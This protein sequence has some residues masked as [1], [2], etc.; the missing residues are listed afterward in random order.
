MTEPGSGL[1]RG[2]AVALAAAAMA[3]GAGG[4]ALGAAADPKPV[5]A[6]AT[7][8]AEPARSGSVLAR[9]RLESS[10]A[11]AE[12]RRAG[13]RIAATPD[14]RSF[15]V[16]SP[17]G[18]RGGKAIV[19]FHGYLSTAFD[20]F[21]QFR[22][23]AARRGYTLIAIH[24]RL[25]RT[26]RD[27]YTPRQMYAQARILLGRAG[28][29]PGD[30][31]LHGYSSAAPR[32]YGVTALDRRG[33]KLFA[34]SIG[35]AG[36]ARP[37]LPMYREVFGGGLGP[38][39]LAGS[40]WVLFCGARDPDPRLTGCPIMRRTRALIVRRGGTVERFIVDP[41]ASHG[42]FHSNPANQRAALDVFARLSP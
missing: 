26:A 8:I 17:A 30:A 38:R 12:A 28:V 15:Y 41:R 2:G 35:D 4:V 7:A 24:W 21:E 13:A 3:A 40:R 9:A 34:L 14:G 42:G 27:S 32:V 37:A 1:T 33:P 39:P 36:G 23:E 18:A 19:T 31:L 29:A 6:R 20:G 11:Y 16:M 25:G 22:A 5:E 10:Q